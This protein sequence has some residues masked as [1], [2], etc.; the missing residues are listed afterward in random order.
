MHVC[1]MFAVTVYSTSTMC[2]CDTLLPNIQYSQFPLRTRNQRTRK[3]AYEYITEEL[4][5]EDDIQFIDEDEQPVNT[6]TN[7]H[8]EDLNAIN[9]IFEN[10]SNDEDALEVKCREVY[11]NG[12]RVIRKIS[13]KIEKDRDELQALSRYG[14]ASIPG[15]AMQFHE[16]QLSV[17]LHSIQLLKIDSSVWGLL[18]QIATLLGLEDTSVV[19]QKCKDLL[20]ETYR[21]EEIIQAKIMSIETHGSEITR[22][23][24][25]K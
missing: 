25:S 7:P 13:D 11:E 2:S 4:E 12:M 3:S 19:D 22:L 15:F 23:G 14:D 6:I 9:L 24:E 1:M 5:H 8:G 16:L 20:A 10:I 17:S 18:D 21:Y